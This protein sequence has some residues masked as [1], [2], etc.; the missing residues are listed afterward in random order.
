MTTA[1]TFSADEFFGSLEREDLDVIEATLSWG[2]DVL[3]VRHL[4]EGSVVSVGEHAQCTFFVPASQLGSDRVEVLSA[5]STALRRDQPLTMALGAFSVG[6]RLVPAGRRVPAGAWGRLKESA[7]GAVGTSFA[8]HAMIL[9]SLAMFLPQLGVTDDDAIL[10]D[11][12]FTMQKYLASAAERERDALQDSV[13]GESSG[14]ESGTAGHEA[15]GESGAIGK[16]ISPQTNGHWSAKG[17][18]DPR[19][20]TLSRDQMKELAR[21]FGLLGILNTW[22]LTDPNAPVVPWG[23]TLNGADRES[24]LGAMWGADALENWGPGGLGL[25][26]VGEGGGCEGDP[27]HCRGVGLTDVGRLG[28]SLTDDFGSCTTPNCDVRGRGQGRLRG[29]HATK[30][31]MFRWCSDQACGFE[32]NGRIPPE[33]IQRIVRQNAGR[34]RLCYEQGLRNN[35][36]LSGHV[37]VK[38]VIDHGGAVSVAQDGGSDIPDEKVRSCVVQSF[39]ALSFPS[40]EG[41]TVRVAYPIIF[42]PSE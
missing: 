16:P 22:P 6:L 27:S 33:V 41:G 35:P 3:S 1:A 29:A 21:D 32:T 40:P 10:R 19:E 5:G 37:R 34:Y 4:P 31:P 24:H 8:A 17:D 23:E 38:F 14:G 30:G 20:A 9:G 18:A 12:L 2:N 15:R 39:Y 26:G 36:N 7:L 11:Q 25:L 13:R 28:H 42:S